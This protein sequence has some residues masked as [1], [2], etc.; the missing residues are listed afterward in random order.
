[1]KTQQE[2]ILCKT[3]VQ[4]SRMSPA[5]KAISN[6]LLRKDISIVYLVTK[7]ELSRELVTTYIKS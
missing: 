1:M 7:V 2:K 4:P 5:E 6:L 3:S